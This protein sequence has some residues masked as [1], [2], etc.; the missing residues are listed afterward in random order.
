AAFRTLGPKYRQIVDALAAD[1]S[2]DAETARRLLPPEYARGPASSPPPLSGR[3]ERVH[4]ARAQRAS[5]DTAAA[6]VAAQIDPLHMCA[7]FSL[8]PDSEALRQPS[9][10]IATPFDNHPEIQ[11]QR[12]EQYFMFV[13]RQKPDGGPGY[14]IPVLG[15]VLARSATVLGCTQDALIRRLAAME[16]ALAKAMGV[17]T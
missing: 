2:L 3:E 9:A 7:L 6:A 10:S 8:L 17:A 16:A 12:G 13:T 4:A 1:R 14:M 11:L 15:L 5:D